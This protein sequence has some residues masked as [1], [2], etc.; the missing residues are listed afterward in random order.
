MDHNEAPVVFFTQVKN[1]AGF[2]WNV[3]FRGKEN[4]DVFNVAPEFE[5]RCKEFGWTPVE[6][7]SGPGRP[8][9]ST[10]PPVEY[11]AHPCPICGE[12]V[13]LGKT[14]KDNKPYEKCSTQKYDF[15]TQTKSGCSYF[16][17]LTS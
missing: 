7:K 1:P 3:T 8:F 12:K 6:P 4:A 9:G 15:Q 16:V 13:V 14:T 2:T 5:K 10:K 11:A 17:W